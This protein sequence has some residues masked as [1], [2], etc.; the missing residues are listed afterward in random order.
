[1]LWMVIADLNR[2]I[3]INITNIKIEIY[4]RGKEVQDIKTIATTKS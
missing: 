2:V 3:K 1:M 4:T